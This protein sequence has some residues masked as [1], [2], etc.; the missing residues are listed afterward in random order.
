MN[1]AKRNGD[2]RSEGGDSKSAQPSR[3]GPQLERWAGQPLGRRRRGDGRHASAMMINELGLDAI[4]S[5][6]IGLAQEERGAVERRDGSASWQVG[7]LAE[8]L[9]RGDEPAAATSEGRSA[10]H[11]RHASKCETDSSAAPQATT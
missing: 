9:A 7:D 3:E 6:A 11:G 2:G 5:Q 10:R 4:G 8:Q 1:N